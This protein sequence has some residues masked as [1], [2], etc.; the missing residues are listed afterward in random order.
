MSE[1]IERIE[2]SL[3]YA[4]KQVAIADRLLKLSD[5]RDF[6]EII[7][8]GYCKEE[9]ARLT[10]LLGDPNTSLDQN[11]VMDDLKSIAAFQRYLRRIIEF[12][13]MMRK[14]IITHESVMDQMR[15]ES[16]E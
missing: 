6:K 15:Q 5:N 3:E 14:D 9:A 16:E 4:K 1:E 2:I 7:L 8:N 10:G 11:G 13:E 12:G